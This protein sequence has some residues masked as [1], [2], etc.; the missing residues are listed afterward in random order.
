MYSGRIENVLVKE[1]KE[2]S[3][4]FITKTPEAAFFSKEG[5][6]RNSLLAAY[7]LKFSGAQIVQD[8]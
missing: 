4:S 2:V 6:M 7:E 8:F 1:D 3:A 5:K